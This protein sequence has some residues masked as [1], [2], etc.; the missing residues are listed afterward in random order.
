MRVRPEFEIELRADAAR[1]VGF[2]EY[3]EVVVSYGRG[4]L[5]NL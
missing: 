5:V 2:Q 1:L 3:R 4:K